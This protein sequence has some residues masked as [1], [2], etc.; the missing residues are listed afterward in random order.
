MYINRF[1]KGDLRAAAR[2]RL[3]ATAQTTS[4]RLQDKGHIPGDE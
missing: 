1:A 4:T 3:M 2:K